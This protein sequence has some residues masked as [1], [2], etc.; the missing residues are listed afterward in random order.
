MSTD[1]PH[2]PHLFVIDRLLGLRDVLCLCFVYFDGSVKLREMARKRNLWA[3]YRFLNYYF[4]SPFLA[5]PPT[6]YMRPACLRH[7]E[8]LCLYHSSARDESCR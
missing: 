3:A 5:R 1:T 8:L 7:L 4:Q 2:L 6:F